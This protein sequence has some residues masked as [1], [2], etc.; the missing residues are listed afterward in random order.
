[1]RTRRESSSTRITED[2]ITAARDQITVEAAA[3]EDDAIISVVVVK[4]KTT[5]VD[6]GEMMI[7]ETMDLD[8]IAVIFPGTLAGKRLRLILATSLG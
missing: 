7:G 5:R 4:M 8:R 1:M 3:A 2:T 6:F